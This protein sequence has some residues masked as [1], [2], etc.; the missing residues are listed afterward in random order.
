[1][2]IPIQIWMGGKAKNQNLWAMPACFMIWF[3][4]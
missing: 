1:M 4:V 2:W 3:A